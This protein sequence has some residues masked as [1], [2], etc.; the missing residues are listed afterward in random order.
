MR[1]FIGRIVRA[2]TG[3]AVRSRIGGTSTIGWTY[4]DVIATMV[5]MIE[6]RGYECGSSRHR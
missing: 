3:I 1:S 4:V 6:Q 2:G 5:A